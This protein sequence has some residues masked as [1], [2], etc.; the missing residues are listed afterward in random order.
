MQ[1]KKLPARH[2]SWLVKI[3]KVQPE[4]EGAGP[5]SEG[6]MLIKRDIPTIIGFGPQGGNFHAPNEYAEAASIEKSLQFLTE[7]SLQLDKEN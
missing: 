2:L 5:A 6:Y 1:M 7:L 4:I 3:Y